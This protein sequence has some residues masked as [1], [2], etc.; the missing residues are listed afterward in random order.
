[1]T[2]FFIKWSSLVTT[3]NIQNPDRLVLSDSILVGLSNGPVFEPFK[4]RTYRSG[5]RMVASLDRFINKR[6]MKKNI[7][8]TKRSWLEVKKLR[9]GFGMVKTKWPPTIVKPDKWSGFRKVQD[10][11]VLSWI[12]YFLW[13]FS[14]IKRSRLVDQSKS[15][16]SGFR[17][18]T[19][20][21][22]LNG[23]LWWRL[24]IKPWSDIWTICPVNRMIAKLDR[25]KSHKQNF[26]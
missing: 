2:L 5:F 20:F 10:Q 4:N 25:F 16:R 23:W 13:L 3:V 22:I 19:V 1:V 7:F 14:F 18:L 11:T 26:I 8:I 21:R 15:G 12:K 17:M 9:S 6:V 24:D